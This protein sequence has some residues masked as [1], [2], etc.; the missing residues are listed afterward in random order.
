VLFLY[1][2]CHFQGLSTF[3]LAQIQNNS[4][5][6]KIRCKPI[7]RHRHRRTFK[8]IT[9]V[10][11]FSLEHFKYWRFH[12]M[13]IVW[14]RQSKNFLMSN[15]FQNIGANS[16][17]FLISSLVGRKGATTLDIMTLAIMTFSITVNKTWRS[18]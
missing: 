9:Q 17:S 3:I 1:F 15:F 11:T 14:S 10:L 2:K 4:S 12:F 8:S 13:K 16:H 5:N 7:Q 18:P 6:N